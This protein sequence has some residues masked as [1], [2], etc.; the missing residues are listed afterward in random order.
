MALFNYTAKEITLKIVYY[1]PGFSGKTTSL[2]YLHTVLPSDAKGKLISMATEGDRT[3]FFDFLP[4]EI[5]KIKDF[6]I[7]FQMYTV[8]GQVRY[9]ATRRLVLKG[10]DA[11]IFVA[12]SQIEMNEQNIESFDNM[13]DNLTVNNIPLDIP[14][15]FQYNKRDISNIM[16]IEE[17]NSSLN[18]EGYPYFETVAAEGKGVNQAFERITKDVLDYIKE[19]HNVDI[20]VPVSSIIPEDA[21][22]SKLGKADHIR[23]RDAHTSP[24]AK[25]PSFPKPEKPVSADTADIK[26][27]T[28]TVK[29]ETAQ[30]TVQPPVAESKPSVEH[31]TSRPAETTSPVVIDISEVVSAI[32][33]LND[34]VVDI[35][36]GLRGIQINQIKN[37]DA[38]N[39]LKQI[40]SKGKDKWFKRFLK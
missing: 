12:D 39:E 9:N 24:V 35:S 1:G 11:I 40:F 2:Q 7:R 22:P 16:S 18:K 8:P 32:K 28:E 38:L 36:R 25:S 6:N 21:T 34:S 30:T 31:V 19:K 10:A 17:L 26:P 3:I 23:L 4:I 14:K 33:S 13:I 29:S 15:V 5:G 20:D 27:V 37:T